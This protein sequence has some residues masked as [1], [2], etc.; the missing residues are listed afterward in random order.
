M[1]RE[2]E[3]IFTLESIFNLGKMLS[4][5]GSPDEVMKISVLSLMGKLKMKRGAGFICDENELKLVCAIGVEVK[6]S[7]G[8]RINPGKIPAEFTELSGSKVKSFGSKLRDFI[9]GNNFN[10]L[11]PV[12]WVM[13]NQ[14]LGLILLGGGNRKFAKS[15]IDY[16]EFVSNFTAISLKNMFSILRLE[17]SIYNLS[18]LNEFTRNIFLKRDESGVFNS[19]ALTLMGHFKIKNVSVVIYDGKKMRIFS[20]PKMETFS[21]K[22]LKK[23]LTQDKPVVMLSSGSMSQKF[24]SAIVNRASDGEKAY[25]LLLGATMGKKRSFKDEDLKLIQTLFTTSISAVENLKA[26]SLNYDINLASE[27]QKNLLPGKFP[28]DPRVDI[29][30]LTIPSKV[31]GGDYYDVIQLDRDEIIIVI[32]DVCGK[33]LSASLLM[34][35]LQASLRS[36]LLFTR[37]ISFVVKL[38]NKIILLN[39]SPEQF[40]SFFICKLNLNEFYLEYVNAGHNPP[41]LFTKGDGV[42]FLDEGGPVL[43]VVECEYKFEKVKLDSGN[44]LFLYTD[45]V[46]EAMDR[47]GDE[48]G[49]ERVLDVVNSL[50]NFPAFRIVE[51]VNKLI[52]KHSY[53][54][55]QSDDITMLV[56]K[57]K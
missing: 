21:K 11:L 49:V 13:P 15:E 2:Q 46:I 25:I 45:G 3:A 47:A 50:K 27:I 42:K 24:S 22:F 17:K 9:R 53:G 55:E 40:I 56:V 34:S 6:T 31:V 48:L 32:A 1:R 18:M 35:N 54:V 7:D 23:I 44:L 20:L 28:E 57:V 4:T 37:D 8:F 10:Y 19:L 12:R 26:L 14:I 52:S 43:G 36:F 16:I 51:G 29:Y 41:A 39:T 5:A 30:G 38:L 33:G